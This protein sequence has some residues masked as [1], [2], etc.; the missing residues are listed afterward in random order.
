MYLEY[1]FQF[2]NNE[3]TI[4]IKKNPTRFIYIKIATLITI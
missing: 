3:H 2:I 4:V 1:I